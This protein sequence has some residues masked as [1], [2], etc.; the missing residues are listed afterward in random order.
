M[1]DR[2]ATEVIDDQESSEE[3]KKRIENNI[4]F[5]HQWVYM[6]YSYNE[7]NLNNICIL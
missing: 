6:Y 5:L 4:L 1:I 2:I 3:E 7:V